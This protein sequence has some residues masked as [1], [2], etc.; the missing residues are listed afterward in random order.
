MTWWTV[1]AVSEA[2]PCVP[3]QIN[4]KA[5]FPKPVMS[6]RCSQQVFLCLRPDLKREEL[7]SFY[8]SVKVFS[9]LGGTLEEHDAR[10]KAIKNIKFNSARREY[11]HDSV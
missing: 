8:L 7:K 11:S 3:S 10:Y 4:K 1:A 2:T 9:A 6:R 5:N